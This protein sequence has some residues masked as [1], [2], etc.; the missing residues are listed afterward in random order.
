M[1]SY[2]ISAMETL[3]AAAVKWHNG[4]PPT[5]DHLEFAHEYALEASTARNHDIK[6]KILFILDGV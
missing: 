4:A 5:L 3:L 2:L 6:I 1:I